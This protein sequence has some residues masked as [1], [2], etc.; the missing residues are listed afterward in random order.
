MK[1]LQFPWVIRELI[2]KQDTD[3]SEESL[4]RY[5]DIK[6]IR[7]NLGSIGKV[8]V[9]HVEEYFSDPQSEQSLRLVKI[10][11][12]LQTLLQT[13]KRGL[14]IIT[15]IPEQMIVY[16]HGLAYIWALTMQKSAGIVNTKDLCKICNL[17]TA[18]FYA[19][20]YFEAFTAHKYLS[21]LGLV[22]FSP[23]VGKAFQTIAPE[24]TGLMVS[25]VREISDNFTVMV[26]AVALDEAEMSVK[27]NIIK[28]SEQQFYTNKNNYGEVIG[29]LMSRNF[30]ELV[31]PLSLETKKSIAF[32]N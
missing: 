9:G 14:N 32:I 11:K 13:K 18:S 23:V 15:N 20:D 5:L 22:D 25:R 31:M 24:L 12:H 27:E 30:G 26:S 29:T 17:S 7:N 6:A 1:L 2:N 19:E 10:T 16:L 4:E 21:F 3:L 8:D 28:I